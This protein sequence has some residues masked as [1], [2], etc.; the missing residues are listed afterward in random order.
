MIAAFISVVPS[1]S[2]QA[3]SDGP[4]ANLTSLTMDQVRL[5]LAAAQS[6]GI[7]GSISVSVEDDDDPD[8]DPGDYEDDRLSYSL[9]WGRHRS[10]PKSWFQPVTEP[11]KA[12]VELMAGG[13]F[14]RLRAKK[15][16]NVRRMLRERELGCKGRG[17]GIEKE[18]FA[19]VSQNFLFAA[20]CRIFGLSLLVRT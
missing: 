6:R 11:Q 9:P 19:R 13:E 1:Q 7:R 5:L 3:D 12:G 10:Q 2:D 18:D 17:R 14:G 20:G 8:Y 16:V 4:T 15:I